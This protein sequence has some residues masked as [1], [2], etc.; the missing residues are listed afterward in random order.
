MSWLKR[1]LKQTSAY[2]LYMRLKYATQMPEYKKGYPN[3]RKYPD[4]RLVTYCNIMAR[5]FLDKRCNHVWIMGDLINHYDYDIRCI[6]PNAGVTTCILGT[7]I[8]DAYDNVMRYSDARMVLEWTAKEAQHRANS[9]YVVWGVSKKYDHEFIVC[10]DWKG[11]YDKRGV[12]VAQAGYY[13]GIFY[14]T[15]KKAFGVAGLDPEIK[16][17]EFPGYKE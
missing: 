5:D 11:F 3:R 15:D 4:G 7:S 9:G 12:L 8:A 2:I 17:Y 1:V 14:I 16:F 13:N 10:P 6:N